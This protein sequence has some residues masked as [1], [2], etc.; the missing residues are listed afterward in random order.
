MRYQEYISSRLRL[1]PVGMVVMIFLMMGIS[2]VML[3]AVGGGSMSPWAMGQFYRFLLGI[4]VMVIAC[5]LPSS[6]WYRSA[7]FLYLGVLALLI[8]LEIQGDSRGEVNRWLQVKTLTFQPSEAVRVALILALSRYL[9]SFQRLQWRSILGAL[10]LIGIPVILVVKQPDLGTG[11]VLGMIGVAVLFVRGLRWQV[12]L[13]LG[14]SFLMSLPFL[15]RWMAV[16]QKE[17][18]LVFFNVNRDVLGDGYHI[19][20]SKIA[21]GSG[22]WEGKGYLQGSQS[23]LDFLPEQHTDFVFTLMGEEFGFIGVLAFLGLFFCVIGYGWYMALKCG[24]MFEKL[25]VASFICSFFLY[26]FVNVGM[27]SGFVPVVG[28]PLPFLSYGG[29]SNVVWLLLV[30]IACS[31]YLSSCLK[32]PK[33]FASDHR[34]L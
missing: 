6:V 19:W 17:R 9:S 1:F 28:L 10:V 5:F 32:R 26:G 24:G 27:V 2:L 7:Y 20:Q 30:G 16:Y 4:F 34:A 12:L 13:G 11:I 33:V 25:T 29:S 18:I 3:Y 23:R 22:G 15:W 21:F 31:C 8:I 14:G